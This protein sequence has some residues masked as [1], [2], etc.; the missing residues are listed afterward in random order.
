MLVTFLP[1]TLAQSL[2]KIEQCYV[3]GA[4]EGND[5]THNLDMQNHRNLVVRV[6][7]A[8]LTGCCN[9]ELPVGKHNQ[10]FDNLVEHEC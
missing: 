8:M 5:P 9:P 4:D 10:D 6:L 2:P 1:R 3:S 7:T